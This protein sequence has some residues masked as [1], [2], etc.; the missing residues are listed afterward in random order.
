MW[1]RGNPILRACEIRGRKEGF[2]R[3]AGL[4]GKAGVRGGMAS[5]LFV[6]KALLYSGVGVDPAVAQE[7]PVAADV[8]QV[9]EVH[10]PV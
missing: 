2:L 3:K 7:G 8:F 6:E 5:R 10:F 1:L 4:R 9:R